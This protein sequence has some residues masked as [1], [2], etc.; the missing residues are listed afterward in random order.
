LI[1]FDPFFISLILK[2]NNNNNKKRD[3]SYN[4][5]NQFP[6]KIYNF[7]SLQQLYFFF[8]FSFFQKFK[9][10]IS[11]FRFFRDLSHNK[12]SGDIPSGIFT[13]QSLT[14]LFDFSFSFLFSFLS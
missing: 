5:F 1:Y 11:K 14:Y 2:S 7:A 9:V 3:L 10:F 8:S 4:S 12:I 6:G 13:L